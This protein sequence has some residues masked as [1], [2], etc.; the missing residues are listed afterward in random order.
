MKKKV[1]TIIINLLLFWVVSDMFSGIEINEGVLGFVICGGIFGLVMLAVEPLIKF[2]TLPVKFITLFFVSIMLSIMI[3]FILN[4]GIPF[5][6]FKDGELVGL[7]NRYFTVPTVNL[8]MIGNVLVGGLT[9]GIL[10][11]ALMWLEKNSGRD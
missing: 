10:S 1:L 3:F 7:S 5:I 9:A 11:S 8:N 2:F 4:I 6:D